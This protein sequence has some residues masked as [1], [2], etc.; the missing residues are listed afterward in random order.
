MKALENVDNVDTRL[1]VH[2]R[3]RRALGAVLRAVDAFEDLVKGGNEELL[4]EMDLEHLDHLAD[5]L[6]ALA[7]GGTIRQVKGAVRGWR[8]TSLSGTR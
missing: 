3:K 8:V 5:L 7:D 1:V 6:E 4:A 2:F